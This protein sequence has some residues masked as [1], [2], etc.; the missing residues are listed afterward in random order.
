MI[1]PLPPAPELRLAAATPGDA[2]PETPPT[3]DAPNEL[4]SIRRIGLSILLLLALA[5]CWLAQAIL[6]PLVL[7]LLL[8]LLLSPVVS[9]LERAIR[10]PRA[11]ATVVVIMLLVAALVGSIAQL[12]QPAQRWIAT[13]PAQMKEL[14]RRFQG[15]REPIRQA[16]E[17]GRTVDDLTQGGEPDT[18][19]QGRPGLLSN[20]VDSTPKMLGSMA[21][22][23]LLMYFFLSSGNRFLR[24]M[25]EV[26]PSLTNKKVVVSIAREVQQEMSRYL[27]MVS[28]INAVLGAATALALWLLGV[29][30]PLLWG[31]VAFAL[32][33]V[34]YVGPLC[35]LLALGLAGFAT[36]DTTGAALAVPGV[37][38]LLTAL[39]GQLLTPTI[40]GR[41]LSLDPTAVFVWLMLWGWLWGVIGILLAGPLLACF[42]IVCQ[43]V[44]SLRSVG[45]LI[46][47]GSERDAR[48]G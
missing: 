37:F 39:E 30:N 21:A 35:T 44:E 41:R 9:L 33:F 8:S 27:V 12:A 7:A 31:A 11:L 36:F 10:L 3:A 19:S 32:N 14:E 5:V 16:Q 42:R 1:A 23:L 25:V 40:L 24:R 6:V 43:H 18:V 13:A 20:L 45:V 46:G 15:L 26:A 48:D 29:P 28:L 2:S 17:A 22:V 47:D 38:F 4:Q 34:P